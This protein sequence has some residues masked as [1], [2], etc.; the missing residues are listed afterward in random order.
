MD[1]NLKI[2][3]ELIRLAKTLVVEDKDSTTTSMT[4]Q[5]ML[6]FL[7]SQIKNVEIIVKLPEN[8]KIV[9][10]DK[11]IDNKREAG[12]QKYP[13]HGKK[14]RNEK[15]IKQFEKEQ[16]EKQKDLN[17]I[18]AKWEQLAATVA[19][20][21]EGNNGKSFYGDL[22][23]KVLKNRSIKVKIER[24]NNSFNH[25]QRTDDPYDD[26]NNKNNPYLYEGIN[27][28]DDYRTF[29]IDKFEKNLMDFSECIVNPRDFDMPLDVFSTKA[30]I[31]KTAQE[32]T[33]YVKFGIHN[34][35]A[36]TPEAKIELEFESFSFHPPKYQMK[37]ESNNNNSSS[38]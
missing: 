5:D 22:T 20:L 27:S 8:E 16:E 37:T 38:K 1:N 34:V 12:R 9:E 15:I 7:Y 3:K 13:Q 23:V 35:N 21:P 32:I 24:K 19:S 33:V 10:S 36:S 4:K 25:S 29:L 17:D 30:T 31:K 26:E 14:T 18:N 11:S 2:A 28:I 6:D